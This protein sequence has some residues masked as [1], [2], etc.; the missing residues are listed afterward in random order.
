MWFFSYEDQ[1]LVE[2][3]PIFIMF[4]QYILSINGEFRYYWL[5]KLKLLPE[6]NGIVNKYKFDF[7]QISPEFIYFYF[8]NHLKIIY[9]QPVG[10]HKTN[11]S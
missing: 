4:S 11:K 8:D 10:H 2:I 6:N 5:R 1:A 9:L 7:L 3:L